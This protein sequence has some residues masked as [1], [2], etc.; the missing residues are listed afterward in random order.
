MLALLPFAVKELEYR[1]VSRRMLNKGR[2]DLEKR[3]AQSGRPALGNVPFLRVK[4]AGLAGR[5]IYT[6][7]G[8]SGLLAVKAAHVTDLRHELW[9]EYRTDTE[10]PHDDW[11]LWKL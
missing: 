10:H 11:I 9:T 7:K 1:I 2:H 6:G 3:L 8:H 4:G 5:R